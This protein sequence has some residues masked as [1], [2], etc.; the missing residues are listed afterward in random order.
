MMAYS[1]QQTQRKLQTLG[2]VGIVAAAA[3]SLIAVAPALGGGGASGSVSSYL[4]N[5]TL[6]EGSGQGA[7]GSAPFLQTTTVSIPVDQ[8]NLTKVTFHVSY[9][10]NSISPLFNPTVTVTV[11]G[12]DGGGTSGT[13]SPGQNAMFEVPVNNL[14]PENQ[15]VDATSPDE[16]LQKAVGGDVNSTLGVGDW[17]VEIDVGAPL[18]GRIRPSGTI[19]Y[20]ITLDFSY[21]EGIAEKA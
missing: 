4:V 17:S 15:T 5:Y 9:Q 20:T 13:V 21:F 8:V 1:V 18:G 16:A 3:L 14:V 7:S 19:T 2:I 6:M 10:D 11:Q 12:P